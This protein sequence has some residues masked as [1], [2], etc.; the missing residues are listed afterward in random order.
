[1]CWFTASL[2]DVIRGLNGKNALSLRFSSGGT[3]N[4]ATD[5]NARVD[6]IGQLLHVSCAAPT[7]RIKSSSTP[8]PR[9]RPRFSPGWEKSW[10][11]PIAGPNP[12]TRRRLHAFLRG[13]P[14][15]GFAW[16]LRAMIYTS[17]MSIR[18]TV[19]MLHGSKVETRYSDRAESVAPTCEL[20]ENNNTL[21]TIRVKHGEAQ[22]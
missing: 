2:L 14:Y 12:R 20:R 11:P 17:D 15:V 21:T 8:R 4:A 7:S 19:C 10:P 3:A 1:L 6:G 22:L 16:V 9:R 18:N 13:E 5:V